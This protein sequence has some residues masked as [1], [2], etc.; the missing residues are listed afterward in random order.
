MLLSLIISLIILKYCFWNF[1]SM[2]AFE[3][4]SS[5]KTKNISFGNSFICFI[6]EKSD[7]FITISWT[8]S[9][10]LESATLFKTSRLLCWRRYI[11]GS[12]SLNLLWLFYKY[13]ISDF[14]SPLVSYS[15][16]AGWY[17]SL[18]IDGNL[19]VKFSGMLR[20]IFLSRLSLNTYKWKST[21]YFNST[22]LGCS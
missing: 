11:Y 21:N 18:Y 5:K 2:L 1:G 22:V 20:L 12:N 4:I 9:S 16:E 17:S 7:I 13:N 8:A 19:K 14:K 15:P 3:I 6:F 10:T